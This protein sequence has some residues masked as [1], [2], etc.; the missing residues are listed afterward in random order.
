[1]FCHKP[2]WPM[3]DGGTVATARM[4][5]GLVDRGVEVEVIA[6]ATSK[7]P[8]GAGIPGAIRCDEVEVDTRLRISGALA[9]LFR[10]TP[11]QLDRFFDRS[12]LEFLRDR[13]RRSEPDVL[14]LDGVGVLPY[15]QYLR[16]VFEGIVIYRA[17]NAEFRI[18]RD[19][20]RA[21]RAPVSWWLNRQADRLERME[22]AACREV[23]GVVA[24]SEPVAAQCREWTE[25]PVTVIGVGVPVVGTPQVAT[26]G[27][28][29]HLGAMDW[30]P[31]REGV[32]WFLR[33]VWPEV[34]RRHPQLDLHL[35]GRRSEIL[36][37]E[38]S[39]TGVVIDGEV[40]NVADYLLNHGLMVVPLLSGS[41]LR[42]KIIEG[43]ALG[44]A[45][46]ASPVAAEGLGVEDGRHLLVADDA[47]Q[48]IAAID[49]CLGD[50]SLVAGLG[51][52]A[53]AFARSSYLISDLSGALE[54]FYRLLAKS[55][56]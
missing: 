33:E 43:M 48:W 1:M 35:A 38:A 13:L 6:L 46:I 39:G 45:M 12:V 11:Y 37:R 25:K 54:K 5:E 17:Q 56:A 8:G 19:R 15:L 7:H 34:R 31:N 47:P 51:I 20:A 26:A 44:K 21:L 16:G 49:R 24:I 2:P 55:T 40:D 41:G 14:Q 28:L 53:H 32:G 22:A 27:D 36:E 50:A 42:V 10:P 4:V 29:V 18:A 30:A 52:E 23:D 3:V 9:N